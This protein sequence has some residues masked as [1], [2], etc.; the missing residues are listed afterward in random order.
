MKKF[1]GIL[2]AVVTTLV[3]LPCCGGGGDDSNTDMRLTEERFC[4]GNFTIQ[5]MKGATTCWV[6]L[7]KEIP[8]TGSLAG[9]WADGQ[10][11]IT[12]DPDHKPDGTGK[13]TC[14]M[15]YE[16]LE[17]DDNNKPKV[18]LLRLNFSDIEGGEGGGDAAVFG[19][20]FNFQAAEGEGG[21]GGANPAP[22]TGLSVKLQFDYESMTWRDLGGGDD[23]N[24]LLIRFDVINR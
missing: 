12:G 22:L 9:I 17:Y 24:D 11:Y 2:L 5:L 20:F 16:V 4:R 18:G 13:H 14:T 6:Y 8:Y 7:T 3:L 21:N 19:A 10:G 23:E 15:N 1:F